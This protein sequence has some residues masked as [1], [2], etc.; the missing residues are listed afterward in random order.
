MLGS[1]VVVVVSF[2]AVGD[3]WWSAGWF[4]FMPHLDDCKG[5]FA[6]LL[7]AFVVVPCKVFMFV[8]ELGH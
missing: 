5:W 1:V 4:W 6:Y 2:I 7:L 3:R 8:V